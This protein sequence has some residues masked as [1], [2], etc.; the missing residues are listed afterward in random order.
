MLA[1]EWKLHSRKKPVTEANA[2]AVSW[3][4]MAIRFSVEDQLIDLG[5]CF[6]T[7]YSTPET[8]RVQMHKFFTSELENTTKLL[9][10]EKQKLF[11]TVKWDNAK[12]GRCCIKA[13]TAKTFFEKRLG[14]L[15]NANKLSSMLDKKAITLEAMATEQANDD[16]VID[17]TDAKPAAA[18]AVSGITREDALLKANSALV[19]QSYNTKVI[20]EHAEDSLRVK[21]ARY[22]LQL[23]DIKQQEE[24]AMATLRFQTEQVKE[25]SKTRAVQKDE[26]QRDDERDM[27]SIVNKIKIAQEVENWDRVA[28]L[29]CKLN[30]LLGE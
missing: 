10:V 23:S 20:A 3:S 18:K 26:K 30:D 29:K 2:F 28:Q 14:H 17:A 16:V 12:Q 22:E 15:T 4:T 6:E 21:R 7:L 5:D 13:G 25:A 19:L 1:H 8:A 24:V 9:G 11:Y 27:Q